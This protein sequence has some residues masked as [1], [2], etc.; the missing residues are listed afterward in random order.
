M[1]GAGRMNRGPYPAARKDG[2]DRRLRARGGLAIRRHPTIP[3]APRAD[4]LFCVPLQWLVLKCPHV[5]GS[6]VPADTELFIRDWRRQ[7]GRPLTYEHGK[8]KRATA[9]RRTYSLFED[10]A[11]KA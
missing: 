3:C 11:Q 2:S 9:E 4:Q 7:G 5:A 6:E 8:A 1:T 10:G